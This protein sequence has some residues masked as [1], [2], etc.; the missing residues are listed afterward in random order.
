MHTR[1]CQI[2]HACIIHTCTHT[3]IH[4]Y[5]LTHIHTCMQIY[6]HTNYRYSETQVDHDVGFFQIGGGGMV[7]VIVNSGDIG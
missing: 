5:I 4:T 6:I 2:L 7:L 3:Y 1:M